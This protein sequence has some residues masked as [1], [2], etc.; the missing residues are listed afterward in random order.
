M[1]RTGGE[2]AEFQEKIHRLHKLM[3]HKDIDNLL[4]T[5]A[6]NFSWLTCGA[7]NFVFFAMSAGAAPLLVTRDKVYLVSNNIESVRQ[8]AE[9]LRDLNIED[10]SHHWH[11]T[12][13]EIT[14]H[15]QSIAKGAIAKDT[16]IENDIKLIRDPLC[17]PEIERYRQLGSRAEEAMRAACMAARPGMTEYEMVGILAKEA[18]SR[19]IWP[20]LMLIASDGRAYSFR[21]PLPTSK[22]I[23]G[24]FMLVLCARRFGLIVSLTRM[25]SFGPVKPEFQRRHEAVCR[26]DAALNLATRPGATLGEILKKGICAYEECGYPDE[27]KLHHQG[28]ITGY[29]GRTHKATPGSATKVMANQAAAW[30]PSIAGTKSE[31]TI[32]VREDGM[33]VLT[34]ARE[35]PMI[36]AEVDGQTMERCGVLTP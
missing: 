32:L 17:E 22:P 15:Y 4:V 1:N 30:N 14:A 21:H 24:H 8:F 16:D 3:Q 18:L 36:R 25:V 27:W 34:A 2:R 28:G 26:V 10:C 19:E 7:E 5:Q 11:A 33:E 20:A 6:H 13:E 31:D 12:N 23:D 35:W 29:L 9:E